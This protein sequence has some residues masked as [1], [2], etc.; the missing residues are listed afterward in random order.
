M[1]QNDLAGIASHTK[2]TDSNYDHIIKVCVAAGCLSANAE[3]VKTQLESEV[4]QRGLENCCKVKGVG[5]MGLCAAGPLVAADTNE[6][7]FQAVTAADAAANKVAGGLPLPSS[8]ITQKFP[9]W[10]PPDTVWFSSRT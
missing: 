4:K 1:N 9:S 5:C 3:Q 6:K 8:N 2:Q 7:M 10:V